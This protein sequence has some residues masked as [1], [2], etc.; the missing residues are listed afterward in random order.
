M[1]DA[2]I[3]DLLDRATAYASNLI[4][5]RSW[6]GAHGGVLPDGNS[7]QDLAQTAFEKILCGAKWDEEKDLKMVLCGIIQG[8]VKNM[9]E[10][11]EN[12]RFSN[13]E[14]EAQSQD[15][16]EAGSVIDR[17]A[18][19]D[20]APDR[21]ASE[22]EDEDLLLEIIESLKDGSEERKIVEAIV[23]SGARKRGE[24]LDDSG[25]N[26]KE[27]EAAKKRLRRFLENYRQER[28]TAHQ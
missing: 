21:K 16:D 25:M 26:E 10:S 9:V 15:D 17:F 24:V 14:D 13:P 6:R 20:S 27:Y 23:F 1:K 2:E 22:R 8:A 12:R 7:A 19:T 18:S 28:A 3:L 5:G 4:R 11:W